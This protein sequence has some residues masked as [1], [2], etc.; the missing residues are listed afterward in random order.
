MKVISQEFSRTFIRFN[1]V[2]ITSFIRFPEDLHKILNCCV[3]FPL[4]PQIEL[5]K[6]FKEFKS[7]RQFKS[8]SE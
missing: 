8:Y 4:I 1:R 2:F 5:Y 6:E 3:A 7:Y